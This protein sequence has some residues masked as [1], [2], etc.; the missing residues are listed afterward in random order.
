MGLSTSEKVFRAIKSDRSQTAHVEYFEYFVMIL[1]SGDLWTSGHT[2]VTLKIQRDRNNSAFT[3]LSSELNT[4]METVIHRG[5][6]TRA[7]GH[8]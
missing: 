6:V 7:P 4:G 2:N 3:V 1:S 8:H 5:N